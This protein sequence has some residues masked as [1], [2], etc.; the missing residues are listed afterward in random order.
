MAV[1]HHTTM[2]PSKLELIAAW[3]PGRLWYHGGAGGPELTKAGGFR[4]DDPDGEVGIEFMVVTDTSG[5]RPIA[6]LL[7]LTY[8]GAP[9]PG[10]EHA[11]VGTGQHGVLGQRWIYDGC[12]DPVLVSEL[13]ALIEGRSQPQAQSVSDTPDHEVARAYTG[14]GLAPEDFATATDDREGTDLAGSHG[15]LRVHR[16]LSPARADDSS[17]GYVTSTWKQPDDTRVRGL[18]VSLRAKDL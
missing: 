13:L 4:L 15:V 1:I 14:A 16:T 9:L 11:L 12:H 10:A 2:E 18:F 6:Y 7:P 5:E 17:P 3:L 8:R